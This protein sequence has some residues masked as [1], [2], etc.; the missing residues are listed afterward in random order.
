M[1]SEH[2]GE[3]ISDRWKVFVPNTLYSVSGKYRQQREER[4]H[5][6]VSAQLSKD[7]I[8]KGDGNQNE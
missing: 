5:Y 3:L 6:Q 1:S 2:F 7:L 8:S 4:I